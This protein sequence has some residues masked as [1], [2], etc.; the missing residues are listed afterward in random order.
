MAIMEA[1]ADAIAGLLA[2]VGQI[3]SLRGHAQTHLAL[4]QP[5]AIAQAYLQVFERL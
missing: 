1:L 5:A 2:D 3:E 4:H